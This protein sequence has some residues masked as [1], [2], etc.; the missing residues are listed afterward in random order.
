MTKK[1][2]GI[3]FQ[4]TGTTTLGEALKILGYKVSGPDLKLIKH[5]NKNE[6]DEV[7]KVS[8]KFDALQDNPW[9]LLYKE[10]DKRYPGSKFI[11]TCR[12]DK[13]W[14][15][16]VV[17]HFGKD[18]TK[19]RKWIYGKASPVGSENI[20]V[21]V[22]RKHYQNVRNYFKD[23]PEDLLEI[24]WA[25]GHAWDELCTFLNQPI[26]SIQFPHSNKRDYNNN[27]IK[28]VKNSLKSLFRFL[29]LR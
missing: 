26:P 15:A 19:M 4:K 16:S 3:G 21:D 28:I 1:V 6:F 8:D 7:F 5:I 22:Y 10:L 27:L 29:G 17:N 2:F 13:K 25:K 20:Y 14:I 24:D 18:K 23:R 9:P 12:D 11:L